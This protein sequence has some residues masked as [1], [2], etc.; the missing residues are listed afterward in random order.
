M[1]TPGSGKDET[2]SQKQPRLVFV[3]TVRNNARLL[4]RC[5]RS[6]AAQT[7]PKTRCVVVDDA[8]EEDTGAV[9]AS[10]S[11]ERP[12]LF[13]VHTVSHRRG[14]MANFYDAVSD[15]DDHDV[16]VELDGDDRLLSTDAAGDLARLHMRLD[17]VWS[18]HRVARHR[19]RT[20]SHFRSTDLPAAYR[21]ASDLPRLRWTRNWHP[22]HLRSF[23][24]WM[25]RQIDPDDLKV[26]G[27][28]VQVCA[29]VAYYTPLVELTPP[30]LRYFYDRELAVYNVTATND[31]F[32]DDP[33]TL[34]AL[35][36]SYV[37]EE[38]FRRQPYRTQPAPLWVGVLHPD[39]RQAIERISE[40]Q[41]RMNPANRFVLAAEHPMLASWHPRVQLVAQYTLADFRAPRP[42]RV[43]DAM[44]WL[45]RF[46]REQAAGSQREVPFPDLPLVRLS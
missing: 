1:L 46:A 22:S 2:V 43:R 12:E 19:W 21:S 13:T 15:L 3:V 24:A 10:W 32:Q 29:D 9:A 17:L 37:A 8:S 4:D 34:P 7:Y 33:D 23:K 39:N 42:D 31:K 11:V 20:W 41:L 28:W 38:I 14:K 5:L 35:R 40:E 44:R 30:A 45:E 18:Q 6:V 36:Q 25:F 16:V 27:D 26:D